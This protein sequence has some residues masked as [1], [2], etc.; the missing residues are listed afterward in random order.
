[1]ASPD[2]RLA[3]GYIETELI[4]YGVQ[5]FP[6]LT[7]YR[8][9]FPL[10]AKSVKNGSN[11][12]FISGATS[13]S[14]PFGKTFFSDP[15]ALNELFD[16]VPLYYA[17]AGS[18]DS[19]RKFYPY[20]LI[21]VSDA[22]VVLLSPPQDAAPDETVNRV[23]GALQ[24]GAKGIILVL[25][26][27]SESQ[28][29]ELT[30]EAVKKQYFLNDG[31]LPDIP[32]VFL[33]TSGVFRDVLRRQE[34]NPKAAQ[35][36]MDF[37]SLPPMML[38]F[39]AAF[40]VGVDIRSDYGTNV[41][42]MLPGNDPDAKDDFIAVSAHYDH[43]GKND[44]TYFPGADDDASGVATVLETARLL[45]GKQHKRPVLFIF[46]SG[47][48]AG[49]LGSKF[50]TANLNGVRNIKTLINIDMIG[51]GSSD[52]LYSIGSARKTA[53]LKKI[54]EDVNNSGAKFVFN[55]KFDS[56]NDPERLYYRSDHYNYAVLG[57][58]VVFF[59]DYMKEDYHLPG[60]TPEKINF[61]KMYRG[62]TLVQNL[63]LRL[64]DGG[65]AYL[66]TQKESK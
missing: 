31:R 29:K 53:E 17:G 54:T 59:Y 4:K 45:S 66:E 32:P 61:V 19:V 63:M 47:E 14:V 5:K 56:D 13:V 50:L 57:I 11:V 58:P 40:S 16:T 49:L 46:H 15:Y 9:Q 60:D 37:T 44:T 35:T 39:K 27:D 12:S 2:E 28:L 3:A 21:N 64:A 1:M 43:L 24:H 55:Y 42:G 8:Q 20:R 52:T 38:P 26:E 62:V 36:Q 10:V 18:D 30:D 41:I 33:I 23:V 65:A 48:E 34:T 25:N 22:F 51:R 7:S 6:G